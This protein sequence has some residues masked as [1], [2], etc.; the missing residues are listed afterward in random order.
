M[1]PTIRIGRLA[2]IA[3]TVAG[4]A[5]CRSGNDATISLADYQ[6]RANA[7]CVPAIDDMDNIV[8]PAIEANLA[9]MGSEPF[10]PNELQ[11]FYGTL[12]EPTDRAGTL[13]DDMLDSLRRLPRP[14]ER[15]DDF[16]ELWA[17]IGTTT[18]RARVDIATAAA[19]ADAAAELWDLDTS[20]FTPIDARAPNSACP[21]AP[22][23]R[24]GPPTAGLSEVASRP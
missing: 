19:N 18:D 15:A 1:N 7:I 16:Q 21:A 23:T 8:Q 24:S 22:S 12:I 10:D 3:T 2:T 6:E 11:T 17:D 13:I 20:P 9:T 14:D 4:L 5:S